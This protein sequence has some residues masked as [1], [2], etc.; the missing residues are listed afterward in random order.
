MLLHLLDG[1]KDVE[2]Q[3]FVPDRSVVAFDI[4]VLLRLA[5]LDLG[6]GDNLLLL[7]SN[8]SVR[9]FV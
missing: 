1:F 5:G 6:Q 8:G 7:G 9:H 2:V 4:S 3:P